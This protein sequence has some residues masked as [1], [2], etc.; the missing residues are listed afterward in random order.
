MYFYERVRNRKEN[1]DGTRI[2]S[3]DGKED[4]NRPHKRISL[5]LFKRADTNGTKIKEVKEMKN[6]WL[7]HLAKVRKAN[8]KIKDVKQLSIIAK[9]TYK[10]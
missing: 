4:S 8:P 9:K 5:L 6:K 10:K 2:R 7:I 1:R 3:K